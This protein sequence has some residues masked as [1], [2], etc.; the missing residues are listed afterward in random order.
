MMTDDIKRL[1]EQLREHAEWAHANE[2]ET[3]ITL[4]DDI[5][6][7]AKMIEKLTRE[8][9]AAI[10]DMKTLADVMDADDERL[11]CIMC[12]KNNERCDVS[13]T[14]FQ[15]RGTIGGTGGDLIDN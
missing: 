5:E 4:G 6:E 13:D 15:W 2:W 14:C 12:A 9:D 11:P 7:A 8:R 3:P 1:V 10:Q